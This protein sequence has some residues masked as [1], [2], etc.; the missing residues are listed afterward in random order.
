MSPHTIEINYDAGRKMSTFKFKD[1]FHEVLWFYM[2]FPSNHLFFPYNAYAAIC[3]RAK[4]V[5]TSFKKLLEIHN[6]LPNE[7]IPSYSP[8][9]GLELTVPRIDRYKFIAEELIFHIKGVLDN[10]VQIIDIRANFERFNKT[11]RVGIDSISGLL[12]VKNKSSNTYQIVFGNNSNFIADSTSFLTTI[13]DLFN[14]FKH[15]MLHL[16]SHRLI[17]HELPS[18]ISYYAKNNDYN[19]IV[20]YH[21]HNAYHLMMG[22]QDNI[23]RINKNLQLADFNCS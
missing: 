14:S 17:S 15:S 9:G 23:D 13:N 8:N 7:P 4:V 16:D 18:I 22:F 5:N 6:R 3:Q 2:R 11:Q 20:Y 1:S 10:L 21:N 19:S 12:N